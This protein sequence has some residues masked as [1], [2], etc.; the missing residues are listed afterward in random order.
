[1]EKGLVFDFHRGTTHDG[2]GMRTTVFFK[3]CP[4]HC[5]WCHNPESIF[6]K[7]EL[8]WDEKKCIGCGTCVTSCPQQALVAGE[9]GIRIL[10][11]RCQRCFQCANHCP[12]KAMKVTGEVWELP[13]LVREACKDQIFFEEFG[14][15][16]TASGGE[17]MAQSEFVGEFLKELKGRGIHTALD[18]S[19]FAAWEKYEKLYPYVDTFLYD[20]K[21][22]DDQEHKQWTG[23][24]NTLIL[25]NLD[26]LAER[27]RKEGKRKLWIR[28]PLIPG[29]T[30]QEDNIRGIG[31]WIRRHVLEVVERWELCAFNNVCRE[32]YKKLGIEWS[33]AQEPL[34]T[35]EDVEALAAIG[36]EWVG[37]RLVVSGLTRV[38]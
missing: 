34:M 36:R 15:G 38:S 20:I 5:K 8:Q 35:K 6:G 30:A 4:L 9:D 1:M 16:V 25:N 22:I 19:G 21:L 29:A 27:M 10:K 37:E 26:L 24:S 12:A 7:P 32:K 18:T 11:E 13:Q 33:F 3:G 23:V 28:T 31:Q 17:P 14:G 2:P